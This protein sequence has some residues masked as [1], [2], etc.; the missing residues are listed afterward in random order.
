MEVETL[1]YRNRELGECQ[2]RLLKL[3]EGKPED[4]LLGNLELFPFQYVPNHEDNK[5]RPSYEA[6]S[7]YW[8]PKVRKE[9]AEVIR[10]IRPDGIFPI[11]LRH[12]LA[13]ALKCLRYPD[14]ERWLWVDA[15]CIFQKKHDPLAI[16][17][18]N[19]QLPLMHEV[20]NRAKHVCVWLGASEANDSRAMKFVSKMVNLE[21]F[22][23]FMNSDGGEEELASLAELLQK[24]WWNRRW[25][26][27]EIAVARDAT[28]F[29][30][31]DQLPWKDFAKAISL[32]ASRYKEVN[33]MFRKSA[34]FG[35]SKL[36][37]SPRRR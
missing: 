29:C 6:L 33:M 28:I 15:L 24:P 23:K 4:A 8:G 26:V 13:S 20:Y 5:L 9:E 27:Q 16:R 37:L 30:G 34:K 31:N 21:Y 19:L 32:F 2:I 17:E 35:H 22:H 18:K 1:P 7:Y 36:R 3:L 10:I 12:N 11:P 14:R 25:I